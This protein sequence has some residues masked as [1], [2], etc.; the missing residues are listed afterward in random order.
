MS[1][2][3]AGGRKSRG[4]CDGTERSGNG[5]VAERSVREEVEERRGVAA[6]EAHRGGGRGGSGGSAGGR[7]EGGA[8][9][10]SREILPA[11]VGDSRFCVS[12]ECTVRKAN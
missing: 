2:A 8:A 12:D 10:A 1:A 5:A 11:V 4:G 6:E 7:R 9:V 3:R